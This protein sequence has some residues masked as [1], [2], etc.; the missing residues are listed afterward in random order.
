MSVPVNS[1]RSTSF[2]IEVSTPPL[3][4][5]SRSMTMTPSMT[6]GTCSGKSGTS[7]DFT[8]HMPVA[9]GSCANVVAVVFDMMTNIDRD[10]G[11]PKPRVSVPTMRE[12]ARVPSRTRR[13]SKAESSVPTPSVPVRRPS[14][15]TTRL[16]G[17]IGNGSSSAVCRLPA[18]TV[19]VAVKVT[20]PVVKAASLSTEAPATRPRTSHV[21]VR[22]EA[23]S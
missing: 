5:P 3:M 8:R 21:P 22:S 12:G 18:V 13:P 11:V 20:E 15:L 10:D 17:A 14:A 1:E 9:S 6:S 2:T 19:P 4:E 23:E 7:R 16:P